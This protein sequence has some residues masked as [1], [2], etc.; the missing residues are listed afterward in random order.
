MFSTPEKIINE[1]DVGSGGKFSSSSSSGEVITNKFER[2]LI[3]PSASL[4]SPFTG[5]DNKI[6]FYCKPEVNR[7]YAS[8]ILHARRSAEESP[9]TDIR[10]VPSPFPSLVF[11]GSYNTHV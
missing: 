8:V 3:K 5:I 6:E 7:L 11:S 2:R 10:Y 1:I 4:R 9:D